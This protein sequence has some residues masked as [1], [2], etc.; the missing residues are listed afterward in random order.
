MIISFRTKR[1]RVKNLFIQAVRQNSAEIDPDV[2]IGLG[3]IFNLTGE[4]DKAVDCFQAALQIRQDDA[5]LWNK[6]GATL[7]NSGKSEQSI[8]AYSRALNLA[9]GY[10]RTRFNLGVACI[11]LSAYKEAVEHFLAALNLQNNSNGPKGERTVT[12][13]NIWTTLRLAISLQG[14]SDMYEACDKRMLNVLNRE[15]GI[16]E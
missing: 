12:S 4:Y 9:P 6:M 11:N 16:K 13:D 7:A 2:Q 15:Y 5:L 1:D 8:E 10:V 3:I 14:R